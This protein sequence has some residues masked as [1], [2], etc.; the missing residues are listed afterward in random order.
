LDRFALATALFGMAAGLAIVSHA[1]GHPTELS[2]HQQHFAALRREVGAARQ[3]Q[4][5]RT[6]GRRQLLRA[7][8]QARSADQTARAAFDVEAT[9]LEARLGWGDRSTVRAAVLAAPMI[10]FSRVA[11]MSREQPVRVA[12]AT[13]AD[14]SSSGGCVACHQTIA[15]PG[16]E[17]YPPPFRTHPRLSAYVGA[18]SP[19]PMSSVAC[20]QCH[21]GSTRATTFASAGHSRLVAPA[22]ETAA[23]GWDDPNMPDA[24]LPVGRT[25][26]ACGGCHAGHLY[27]P[28]APTLNEALI[29]FDRGGCVACH[30]APGMARDRKRGPDLRR[31]RGKLSPQWVRHWLANPRAVKPATWMPRFW[32]GDSAA[33]DA[34]EAAID[35]VSAYLFAN[36][37]DYAPATANPPLGDASRG[38]QLTESVGC[39]GCHVIGDVP[40]DESSVRRTFGQPLQRVGTKTTYAWLFDWLRDPQRY[41]P[42]TLM[43]NLRLSVSEA[44]D[45]STYLTTLTGAP[46]AGRAR[47]VDAKRDRAVI[48]RYAPSESG[49]S[50]DLAPLTGEALHE[51]AGKIVIRALGCFNCHEIRGFEEERT[52]RPIAGRRVWLDA[53]VRS[54]HARRADSHD[55]RGA[56]SAPDYALGVSES[57]R[58][59]LALTAV[60]GSDP[61]EPTSVVPDHEPIQS[62]RD[63]VQRRNCAGCHVIEGV[64]GDLVA[65]AP[66]PTLGPPLLTPEGTRVQPDWL[67]GFLREPRVIRPWLSARMPTFGLSAEEVEQVGRYLQAIAPPNP[68]PTPVPEHASAAAGKELFDLLKCQQCHV[69]GARPKGQPTSNLAPDLRLA[70]Q[71][72]QPEWILAWLRSPSAILPGTRM[73]TFWPDYPTS[74][75]PPLDKSGAAQVMAIRDH[76]L[77]LR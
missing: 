69:L 3:T 36:A 5:A 51:A 12:D 15:T 54:L 65:L 55:D 24:M 47:A 35:S 37:D 43:P 8:A 70:S 45:V 26:A 68:A 40:R 53:D 75:Y 7:R 58:L 57:A 33:A 39:L 61:R 34:N 44:A 72:L 2:L 31:I 1:P 20:T 25:E 76:L 23:R 64:G 71:R 63:L 77:T 46:L 74:F 52:M 32:N 30:V 29:T 17:A 59:A 56:P 60:A 22:S 18:V 49:G 16:Y 73:P 19:H 4:S 38:K 42:D 14:K 48:L 67:R 41:R 6:A 21:Q 28:G 13:S 50:A 9:R 10:Q 62:G 66:E 27:E 11:V